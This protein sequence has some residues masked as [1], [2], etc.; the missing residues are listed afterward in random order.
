MTSIEQLLKSELELERF[1]RRFG[2]LW[3]GD[4]QLQRKFL[5]SLIGNIEIR[6]ARVKFAITF[7]RIKAILWIENILDEDL[8]MQFSNDLRKKPLFGSNSQKNLESL[9]IIYIYIYIYIYLCLCVCMCVYVCMCD[10]SLSKVI[11]LLWLL[12]LLLLLL[13]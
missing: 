4:W 3:P 8:L 7:L 9:S 12:L 13:L 2:L 11:L 6:I 1:D 5:T 10:A